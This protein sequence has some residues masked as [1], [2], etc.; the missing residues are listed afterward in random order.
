MCD[1]GVD[2]ATL[3]KTLG[4]DFEKYFSRELD[5][6]ADLESDGLIER[7]PDGFSVTEVGRLL[8]RNIAMRFDVYLPA[9]KE[10]R[11]SKTI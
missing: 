5:S 7:T 10:R 2:F 6:L 4:I 3:S 8:I 9:E 11:F 1:L